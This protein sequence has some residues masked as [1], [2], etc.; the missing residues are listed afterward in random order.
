MINPNWLQTYKTLVDVGHFTRAAQ[1]LN[2]T[3]PGVSQHLHKLEEVCRCVLIYRD[4]GAFELTEQGR[5][6]Y[7]YAVD[8][9]EIEKQILES[10]LDDIPFS[11]TTRLSCS[12]SVASLLYSQVLKLQLKFPSMITE[13]EASSSAGVIESVLD[14]RADLGILNY[15]PTDHRLMVEQIG[16]EML[17]LMVPLDG[18]IE[19]IR[20]GDLGI[21]RHP[22]VDHY[23]SVYTAND[24]NFASLNIDKIKCVGFVNQLQQILEPVALGI[25]FT[26]LP[27]SVLSTF[28]KQDSIAVVSTETP[29]GESL[30]LIT[31]S[32]RP[33][34]ARYKTLKNLLHNHLNISCENTI[35]EI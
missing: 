8:K 5:R 30:Y 21:I 18:S 29:I 26:V 13:I 32:G 19:V 1:L 6:I 25:G 2:M 4:N 15:R 10:L 20:S 23:L 33:W 12:G 22:D 35:H 17:G 3:Q 9:I 11:G 27:I 24:V 7:Q 28:I 34:P 31:K 16:K 14:D